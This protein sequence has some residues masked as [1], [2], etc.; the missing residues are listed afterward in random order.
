[1]HHTQAAVV[2]DFIRTNSS[3]VEW[4]LSANAS[5]EDAAALEGI[6]AALAQARGVRVLRL[7]QIWP[8]MPAKLAARFMLALASAVRGCTRCA[9]RPPAHMI[10]SQWVQNPRHGDP[11]IALSCHQRRAQ[12]TKTP[13][14]DRSGCV[15]CPS[16]TSS[17]AARRCSTSGM[18]TSTRGRR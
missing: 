18:A 5:I 17:V 10:G 14:H 2:A 11:I 3:V 7:N 8:S 12:L 6:L 13:H 15:R 9:R 1:M 4:D 16:A